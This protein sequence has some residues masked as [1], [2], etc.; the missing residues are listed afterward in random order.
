VLAVMSAATTS[1]RVEVAYREGDLGTGA[2]QARGAVST[3]MPE[4]PPVTMARPAGQ[5]DAGGNL[6]R[7]GLVAEGGS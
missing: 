7:G 6:G 2:G 4:A 5:V 1:A 3:P